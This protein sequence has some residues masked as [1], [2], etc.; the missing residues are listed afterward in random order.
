[1]NQM[2]HLDPLVKARSKWLGHLPI[3]WIE[4]SSGP[5]GHNSIGGGGL[6]VITLADMVRKKDVSERGFF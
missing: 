6:L 1:M 5:S 3:N 2:S 4:F